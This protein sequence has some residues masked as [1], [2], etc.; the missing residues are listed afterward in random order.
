[1]R[2]LL[3]TDKTCTRRFTVDANEIH[4]RVREAI[5]K[6][7]FNFAPPTPLKEKLKLHGL[8]DIMYTGTSNHSNYQRFPSDM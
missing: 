3:A 1:M 6:I 8:P 4:A 7:Y 5:R 2:I